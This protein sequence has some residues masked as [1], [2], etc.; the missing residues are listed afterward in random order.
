MVETTNKNEV[1]PLKGLEPVSIL[2]TIKNPNGLS[3]QEGY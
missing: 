2:T 3:I 1:P